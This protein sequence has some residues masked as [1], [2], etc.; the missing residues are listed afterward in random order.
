VVIAVFDGGFNNLGHLAFQRMN[1]IAARDFVNNDDDVDDGPDMGNGSHGTWTLSVIGGFAEGQ[2]IGPAFGA[3]Y[4]LAK[5]E[6]TQ[7][8][9]PREEDNWVAALEWA[10]GFGVDVISSSLGYLAFDSPFDDY[11]WEDMDG[12]TTV[13]TRAAVMA[14]ERGLVVVNA[15]GN[16]GN[17]S[18]HNTLGAPADGDGVITAGAV[19]PNGRRAFF[20]SVGPTVD[21][22]IKP[23]VMARGVR[24]RVASHVTQQGYLA[25]DG[26]SF[27][28]PLVAG[29][30]ALMLSAHPDWSPAQVLNALRRTASHAADPNSLIGWGIIDALAAVQFSQ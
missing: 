22:R 14:V 2:L 4:I 26:T 30:V 5:T 9:T 17:N 20:S 8:E 3:S 7:S 29:T 12:R 21:G 27:A 28:C 19:N 11:T 24:V 23:D 6:N 16:F 13:I 15:A 18:S 25:L 1:I 10:E